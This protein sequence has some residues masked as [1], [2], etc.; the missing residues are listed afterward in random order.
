MYRCLT[1]APHWWER[2]ALATVLAALAGAFVFSVVWERGPVAGHMRYTYD[3]ARYIRDARNIRDGDSG[4]P[5]YANNGYLVVPLYPQA[6]ALAARAFDG[7]VALGARA[8]GVA[9]GAVTVF[10]VTL[11]VGLVAERRP[12]FYIGA[13]AVCLGPHVTQDSLSVMTDGLYICLAAACVFLMLRCVHRQRLDWTETVLVTAL[14][15]CAVMTR[16]IGL[17]LIPVIVSAALLVATVLNPRS[18]QWPVDLFKAAV[19][20]VVPAIAM[21]LWLRR[22]I[23]LYGQASWHAAKGPANPLSFN[24]A[25]MFDSLSPYLPVDIPSRLARNVWNAHLANAD[26]V[27]SALPGAALLAG[28]TL[29]GAAAALT[30]HTL[31]NRGDLERLL[32]TLRRH[33]MAFALAMFMA[34]I[35]C[36]MF[37]QLLTGENHTIRP[38]RWAPF[39]LL[40]SLFNAWWIERSVTMAV[41]RMRAHHIMRHLRIVPVVVGLLAVSWFGLYHAS[42]QNDRINIKRGAFDPTGNR[43]KD[44]F[45]HLRAEPIPIGHTVYTNQEQIAYLALPE[46]VPAL[47]GLPKEKRQLDR[48]LDS[49]TGYILWVEHNRSQKP[50][51]EVDDLLTLAG[52]GR[53]E[54]VFAGEYGHLFR[55]E[56]A[57]RGG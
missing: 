46:P 8:V 49:K 56:G 57:R 38:R 9:T 21:G 1:G 40:F 4:F 25:N 3:S 44:V 14:C 23:E 54:T 48:M 27:E 20:G 7:D 28:A 13:P 41:R 47:K 5:L 19:I 45:Q 10:L 26:A 22:N 2:V 32:T 15:T 42:N 34:A 18:R 17:T 30:L 24:F 43:S 16:Y 11:S 33:R 35:I 50:A 53:I 29:A 51:Y 31:S 39:F 6:I 12:A 37:A 55:F 36:G 52:E